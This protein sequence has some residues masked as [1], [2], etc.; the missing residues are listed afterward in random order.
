MKCFEMF[1]LSLML[2]SVWI[3]W[4]FESVSSVYILLFSPF[5]TSFPLQKPFLPFLF[6]SPFLSKGL[7]RGWT[8]VLIT[9]TKQ[10]KKYIQ[11]LIY[12]SMPGA[13]CIM[14]GNISHL[15]S[16]A[17]APFCLGIAQITKLVFNLLSE[18][19]GLNK[20]HYLCCNTHQTM[21]ATTCW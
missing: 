4:S 5:F 17:K 9:D 12:F 3:P 14:R 6:S 2:L 19:F 18:Y 10:I 8:L 13:V 21:C 1:P 15:H 11:T 20:K 7:S 16:H